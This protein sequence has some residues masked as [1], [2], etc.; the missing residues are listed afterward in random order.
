MANASENK[1]PVLKIIKNFLICK[2]F[3]HLKTLF[4]LNSSR[5]DVVVD[6]GGNE[7]GSFLF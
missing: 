2:N 1:T 5:D 4:G 3:S 6:G 7:N